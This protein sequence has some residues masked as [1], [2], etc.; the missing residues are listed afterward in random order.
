M[1]I[2]VQIEVPKHSLVKYEMQNG[3]LH[4]DRILPT[5]IPYPFNYGYIPN[6]LGG[7]GDPLDAVVLTEYTLHPGCYVT[8]RALGVLQTE[9]EAGVDSKIILVPTTDGHYTNVEDVHDLPSSTTDTIAYFFRHY[10]ELE[11][12]KWV[13][14]LGILG[15]DRA[16]DIIKQGTIQPKL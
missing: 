8:C 5:P 7:D 2:Q 10:K 15:R 16:A 14:T 4:V 11:A 1:T 6:T 12:G 13:K 9:D 3:R